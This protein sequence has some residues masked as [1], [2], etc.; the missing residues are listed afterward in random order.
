MGW[1]GCAGIFREF[2]NILLPDKSGEQ[3]ADEEN[4]VDQVT[5]FD[6]QNQAADASALLNGSL[7]CQSAPTSMTPTIGLGIQPCPSKKARLSSVLMLDS[8][9]S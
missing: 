1:Q 2:G 6:Q 4:D 3:N 5:G 7:C 9:A 8:R